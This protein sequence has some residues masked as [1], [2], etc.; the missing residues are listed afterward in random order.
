MLPPGGT[1]LPHLVV[2]KNKPVCHSHWTNNKFSKYQSTRY[3]YYI[4]HFISCNSYICTKSSSFS[5]F[6]IYWR[7]FSLA[8]ICCNESLNN[9]LERIWKEGGHT[10]NSGTI[11][12]LPGGTENNRVHGHDSWCPGQNLH[13]HFPNVKSQVLLPESPCPEICSV[14]VN[15]NDN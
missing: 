11:L 12:A 7:M 15:L 2:A 5:L 13:W 6:M 14:T 3:C 4:Y 9:K 1:V 10:V 8:L